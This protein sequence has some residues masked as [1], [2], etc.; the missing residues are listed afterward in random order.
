MFAIVR[1]GSKQYKVAP[2]DIISVDK[3]DGKD[4]DAIKFTEVLLVND[5]KKVHVGTPFVKGYV[6]TATILAQEQGEK[7]AVRR[8][9]SKVRYRRHTGFRSKLTK[10]EIT[11]V[12]HA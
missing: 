2:K 1:I 11:G 12:I 4:G 8:Y 9:K 6:V 5:E 7:I 10:L 3:L